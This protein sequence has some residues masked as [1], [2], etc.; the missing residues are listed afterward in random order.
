MII[1]SVRGR[2]FSKINKNITNREKSEQLT[3]SVLN[4][5]SEEMHCGTSHQFAFYEQ[6]KW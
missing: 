1:G 5:L 4:L 6:V 2:R 3:L